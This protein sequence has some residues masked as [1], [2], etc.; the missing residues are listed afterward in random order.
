MLVILR[1]IV[2]YAYLLILQGQSAL[3]GT[4]TMVL[5]V[6]LHYYLPSQV[7]H[8]AFTMSLMIAESPLSCT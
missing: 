6:F 8:V 5:M 1:L 3:F 7:S 4:D 2:P